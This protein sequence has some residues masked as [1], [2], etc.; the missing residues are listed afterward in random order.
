[1]SKNRKYDIFV[2][3]YKKLG[4]KKTMK[5]MLSLKDKLKILIKKILMKGKQ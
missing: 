3:N 1:M 5:K 4:F 2:T